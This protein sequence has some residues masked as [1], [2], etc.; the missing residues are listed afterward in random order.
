MARK[1]TAKQ[2]YKMKNE[3]LKERLTEVSAYEF[4]RDLFPEGS[5]E[6]RGDYENRKPNAIFTNIL[7]NEKG[8]RY[9]RNTI[10]F[11]DLKELEEVAGS[12]FA[13]CSPITY[14]GR[15][16]T[17][18]NAY[19]LWGFAVDLD[20]VEMD[21][22]EDL[23]YQIGN[24]VLPEP[25]YLV[26]SGHGFHVYYLFEDPI[27]LYRHL[28]EP[29]NRLK[30][31]LTNIVWNRYT[32]TI[33][34]EER[35]F[36]GIFQGFRMPGTQSKLGA[37]YPV[38]VFRYGAKRS[39]RYLNEFV[40]P[41]YRLKEWDDYRLTLEEAKDRYPEWYQKRIIEGNKTRRKWDIAGK[42]NGDNPYALYD[43]WINQ[44]RNGAF[45]GNRYN[46]IAVL[47]TYAV[48]LGISEEKVLND[49]LSLVPWLNSLT[50]T[51]HNDFTEQDVYDALSY[52]SDSYATYSIRAIEAR[53]K[54]RIERNK[55]NGQRQ[56]DHLEE[57]RAIRDIRM[58]R[59][60]KDWRE[61][62]G[63]PIGSGTARMKVQ[64]YRSEHPNATV[65]EVARAIGVSRPTVYKWWNLPANSQRL[66]KIL[67]SKEL[68]DALIKMLEDEQN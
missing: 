61:G 25:T 58:K 43:W 19:Q 8:K 6:I 52:H 68:S 22:L 10:M 46:C 31:G 36:Q 21:Q 41:E 34:G 54:I 49:A 5:L 64:A 13:V 59:L 56:E 17:A 32:S 62:N 14:S 35:Q 47:M 1:P 37:K 3:L 40:A 53:T 18:A 45:D 27:P 15:N 65:T 39:I 20:G 12:E 28:H 4:Y 51:N 23:L 38:I 16:R 24:D 44:I 11:D 57:A 26:N 29:L 63:R 42:V 66:H 9:A 33:K 48:K 2:L 50:K 55:R 30:Q 60:N 67:P 7:F